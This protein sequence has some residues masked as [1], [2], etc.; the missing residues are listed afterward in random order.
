MWVNMPPFPKFLLTL[1]ISP[2]VADVFILAEE[3]GA[4]E[5]PLIANIV[6]GALRGETT[7]AGTGTPLSKTLEPSLKLLRLLAT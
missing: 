4:R 3:L 2:L 7:R 1:N 5:L 6:F